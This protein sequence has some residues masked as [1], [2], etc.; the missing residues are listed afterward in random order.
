MALALV[1]QSNQ[2]CPQPKIREESDSLFSLGLLSGPQS[3]QLQ[4]LQTLEAA[5]AVSGEGQL[6]EGNV[7]PSI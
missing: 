1:N 2:L 4:G 5:A 3:L 6:D 7:I